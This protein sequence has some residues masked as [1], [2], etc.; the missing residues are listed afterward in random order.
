MRRWYPVGDRKIL[1][2]RTLHFVEALGGGNEKP[3][4]Q[5]LELEKIDTGDTQFEYRLDPD[6]EL[7]MESIRKDGQQIPVIL[8]GAG[9]PYQLICG[10]RRVRSIRALGDRKVKAIVIP[11]LSDEQAHR[12][13]VLENEERKSLTDLDRANACERLKKE[14]KKQEEIAVI[15]G[16]SQSKVSKYLSLLKLTGPIFEALKKSKISTKHALILKETKDI[17]PGEYL[18]KLLTEVMEKQLST[19]EL[20]QRIKA[21]KNRDK[22]K[23]ERVLF[24]K[25]ASGFRLSGITYKSWMNEGEK[26]KLRQALKEALSL[27]E[28]VII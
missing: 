3:G 27:L 2:K 21:I 13:S 11:E 12:L 17:F 19:R 7:L 23:P 22:P 14:G 25:T 9:P 24:K 8:R 16:C 20:E 10:F 18:K 26:E 28:G 6:I 1:K 4:V 5:E 15:M